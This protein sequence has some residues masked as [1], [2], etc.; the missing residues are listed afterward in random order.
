MTT[1]PTK[2]IK[3]W[4]MTYFECIHCISDDKKLS[5]YGICENCKIHVITKT[6]PASVTVEAPVYAV[7]DFWKTLESILLKQYATP[8]VQ[9]IMK[10]YQKVCII[11]CHFFVTLLALLVRHFF[12]VLAK[13]FDHCFWYDIFGIYRT[14]KCNIFIL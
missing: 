2:F 11:H 13:D 1:V 3:M 10:Q 7:D 12:S 6:H 4:C 5:E 8:D 14:K 9:K